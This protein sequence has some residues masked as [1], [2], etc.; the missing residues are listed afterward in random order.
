MCMGHS[1]VHVHSVD[2]YKRGKARV[3]LGIDSRRL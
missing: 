3:P 1:R 2:V